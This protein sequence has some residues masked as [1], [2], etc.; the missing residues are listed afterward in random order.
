MAKFF[1]KVFV[2]AQLATSLLLTASIAQAQLPTAVSQALVENGVPL[3]GVSVFVQRVDAPQAIIQHEAD[4]ALN[5]ASTMRLLTTYAGLEL[6]GPAYRWR[7]EIYTDGKLVDG[8]L[9][10][11]LIVKGY[12]DPA[13][14]AE[15]FWRMLNGLRQAG[16]K[17]IRGDLV[18]DRSYFSA[19]NIDAGEF[20]DEPY[21]AYNAVPSALIVNLNSTSLGFSPE[22]S[23]VSVKPDP[24][25]PEIKI[26]NRLKLVQSACGD[27]KSRL[28]YSIAPQPGS[29]TVTLDGVYAAD[30]GSKY[31][32]LSL[33]DDATYTF[34][35]FR[36]IWPQ[37]GGSFRGDLKLGT[38]PDNAVKMLEQDSPTL[39]DVI[40]RINKYSNNLMARQLLLTMAAEREGLPGTEA[41]GDIAIRK[42]L[43]EKGLDF[44]ELVIENGSGLSRIG[45]ISAQHVGELLVNAYT[46]PVMPELMSSLPILAV[47]GTTARRSKTSAAQGRA[48]LKTGSLN[49]VRAIAG[50][51]L[52]QAGRRWVVVFMVNHPRAASTKAAQD[53]LLDW[54][55]QQ[56]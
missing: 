48:H 41:K 39:G 47:D 53:V 37:L 9:H 35:L 5:P 4:K 25:L 6:L 42:W 17:D 32:D 54:V 11:N 31:L 46:S 21:R 40:R 36:K 30:C 29:V 14:M 18:L 3:N 19:A 34:N 16:V 1:S 52:D 13:L 56:R 15:D 12:G 10:G 55:Y 23:G 33:F 24:D 43:A 45:R 38:A 2:S 20:D 49:G 8:V 7:T 44:P 28:R 26:I 51:V 27:W 22:G 50:Y